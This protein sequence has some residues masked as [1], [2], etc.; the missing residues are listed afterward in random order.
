MIWTEDRRFLPSPNYPI[1]MYGRTKLNQTKPYFIE[2]RTKLHYIQQHSFDIWNLILFLHSKTIA[3]F[4]KTQ[5]FFFL[6]T[7][8]I[9]QMSI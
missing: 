9:P 5:T 4:N 6:K 8:V 1:I 2:C 7:E 3:Y